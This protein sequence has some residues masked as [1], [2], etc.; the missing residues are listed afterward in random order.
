[1]NYRKLAALILSCTMAFSLAACAPKAPEAPAPAAEPAAV[2]QPAEEAL[3]LDP[4]MASYYVTAAWLHENQDNVVIVDANGDKAYKAGHIPGAV[5]ITWQSL[6]NMSVKQGEPGWGVVLGQEELAKKLGEF[7]ID[8]SKDI[9][10][11][12][13][14]KGL[15]EE[16]RVLWMLR[17][18]G[19]E[20]SKMLY[21]GIPAWKEAGYE[22]TTEATAVTAVPFTI[23]NYD[24]DRIATTE[25]VKENQKTLKLLDT[26]SPE[27]YNGETTHGENYKGKDALGH[28]EGAVHLHYADLYNVDGTPKSIADLKATFEGLGLKPEDEIVTYCTVGIRSG[29]TA[30]MLR[31]C[32]YSKAKNYNASFSE[33]AGQGLPYVK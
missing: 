3:Q 15:G 31:M 29:F 27:E 13:D 1:M 5:N 26:R 10:V 17:I 22:V 14:P 30:E 33:W 18:A 11:Y 24:S 4:E 23:T 12:N 8:G 21:G 2:A 9:V 28:I 7:G 6:S 20:N 16:G 25:F 19:L 32:G